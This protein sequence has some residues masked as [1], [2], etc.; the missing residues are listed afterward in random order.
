VPP[1][2]LFRAGVS[3]LIDRPPEQPWANLADLTRT[4]LDARGFGA[5]LTTAQLLGSVGH[6][7]LIAD[8]LRRGDLEKFSPWG[9]PSG[10]F[11][12]LAR[13]ALALPDEFE[14]APASEEAA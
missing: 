11:A 10:D 7:D 12:A 3:A 6:H 8:L 14:P 4:Y 9:A 2:E 13:R 5:D 1:A